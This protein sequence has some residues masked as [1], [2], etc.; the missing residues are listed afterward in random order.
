MHSKY[1]RVC[2]GEEEEWE[3]VWLVLCIFA[4]ATGQ[5]P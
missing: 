5:E 1:V 3:W 4:A 2:E